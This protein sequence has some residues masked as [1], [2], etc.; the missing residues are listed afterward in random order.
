MNKE[1]SRK[2][3]IE[4]NIVK[5]NYLHGKLNPQELLDP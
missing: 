4:S 5:E 1:Y 3:K 2:L